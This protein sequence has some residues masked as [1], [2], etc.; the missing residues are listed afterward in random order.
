VARRWRVLVAPLLAVAFLFGVGSAALAQA[1]ALVPHAVCPED[2]TV[3]H[4]G[5]GGSERHD[6]AAIDA[7]RPHAHEMGCRLGDLA[8]VGG[9][10][11]PFP[12]VSTEAPP[13]SVER[14]P[15][16]SSPLVRAIL[17]VAPKT[18]PPTVS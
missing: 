4:A 7:E 1:D 10:V 12:Q 11:P 9:V 5:H 18:S 8:V 3:V 15:P 16:P 13:Q 17:R 2:G 14:A 6:R